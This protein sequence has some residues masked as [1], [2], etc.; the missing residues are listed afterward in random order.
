MDFWKWIN[1][2]KS[3]I[4]STLGAIAMWASAKGWIDQNDMVMIAAMLTVW[5][6]VAVGHKITKGGKK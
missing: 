3:A 6:G 4:G 5:T 1:G 2:K